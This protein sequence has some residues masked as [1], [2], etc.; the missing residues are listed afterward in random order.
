VLTSDDVKHHAM[1]ERAEPPPGRLGSL[2]PFHLV[3]VLVGLGGALITAGSLSDLDL[4]WHVRSGAEIWHRHTTSG[5]GTGWVYG[6]DAK[7]WQTTQWLAE[8]TTYG[9]HQL[10]G[11]TLIRW[12]TAALGAAVSVVLLRNIVRPNAVIATSLLGAVVVLPLAPHLEDRP[13]TISLLLLAALAPRLIRL[14]RGLGDVSLPL[15]LATTLLWVQ[16]HGYWVLLPAA[17][18]LAAV[19]RAADRRL[20]LLDALRPANYATACVLVAC[21]NPLGPAVLLTPFQFGQAHEFISE[22]KSTSLDDVVSWGLLGTVAFMVVAWARSSVAAERSEVLWFLAWCGFGLLA[23][24]N[25][26][27]T[28]VLVAPLVADRV[29]SAF[30]D[31]V[32]TRSTRER[33]GIAVAAAFAVALAVLA[34]VF[35]LS[36]SP[37]LPRSVP[38]H[39]LATLATMQPPPRV[40]NEYNLS[41]QILAFGG[42]ARVAVDGRADLSAPLLPSYLDLIAARGDFEPLFERL[43]PDAALLHKKSAIIRYLRQ[44]GWVE[45]GHEG[46]FLLLQAPAS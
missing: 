23:F 35:R 3:V 38:R 20:S 16:L 24:R 33:R 4:Y 11:Y 8:V 1:T 5:I 15:L 25:V 6:V 19:C 18:L 26:A 36:S 27:V 13:A 31:R 22:W 41:G 17:L 30:P 46:D 28:L 14:A 10:G 43:H 44:H 34:P 45:L 29:A 21:L 40:L 42:E 12:A 39:L 37:D 7:H 32:R 9:L 2:H